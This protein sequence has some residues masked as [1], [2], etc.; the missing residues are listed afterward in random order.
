MIRLFTEKL[1]K[2]H[3]YVKTGLKRNNVYL[4]YL[5]GWIVFF[6]VTVYQT[7]A[8]LSPF[9]SSQASVYMIYDVLPSAV[10]VGG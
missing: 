9:S 7:F 4:S 6:F 2:N 1:F 10:T 5:T 3:F 8:A